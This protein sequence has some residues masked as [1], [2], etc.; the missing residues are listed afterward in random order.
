MPPYQAKVVIVSDLWAELAQE[1]VQAGAEL[2]HDTGIAILGRAQEN[3]PEVSG[4][5]AAS[6]YLVDDQGSTYSAAVAAAQSKNPDV[7][8][9]PEV[10]AERNTTIVAFAV[11]Y[12]AANEFYTGEQNPS[13]H[14]YLTPAAESVRPQF[15]AAVLNLGGRVR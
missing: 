1:Y 10:Q 7:E 5:L 2:R 15:E 3:A 11:V 12:A 14:P 4:A 8:L 9:L 6:G 13:A